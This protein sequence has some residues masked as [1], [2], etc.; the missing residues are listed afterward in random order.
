MEIT[1]ES[2]VFENSLALVPGAVNENGSVDGLV[3]GVRSLART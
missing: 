1:F 3:G 2:R